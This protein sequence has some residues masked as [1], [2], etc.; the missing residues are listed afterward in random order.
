MGSVWGNILKISVF[1]ESHGE[2]I[3]I[4]IDNFPHGLKIDHD[5]ISAQM[6]RRAPG[7]SPGLSTSRAEDD[8]PVIY[9]G[10][11]KGFTTGAPI[12]AI[13]KNTNRRSEDYQHVLRKPRPSH[14]DL[15]A[16]RKYGGFEDGRGGGHFSGRLTAPIVFAGALCSQFLQKYGIDVFS[17]IK[18]IGEVYDDT[19]DYTRFPDDISDILKSERLPFINKAKQ[20]QASELIEKYKKEGNSVGG[21]VECI[22]KNMPTSLGSPIFSSVES[23]LASILFSIPGVKAV[24][25]GA[26]TDFSALDAKRAN[27]EYYYDESG[28]IKTKT[29]NNGGILGGIT[30]GMPVVFTVTLKPTPSIYSAQNT[31]DLIDGCDTKINIEGRHD[32][33]IAVR[34]VP[35]TESAAMIAVMDMILCGGEIGGK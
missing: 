23:S 3:G 33:C 7:L 32:P 30:T 20:R 4:V 12:C 17:H 18:N 13:I 24:E 29:N 2:C 19:P 34:A 11:L 21:A 10:V 15:P 14:A 31:V 8:S 26:G 27:D 28:N 9:S 22:I 25:F 35:V 6:R 5:H 1:G 16:H